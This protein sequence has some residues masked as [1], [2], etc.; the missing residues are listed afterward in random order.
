MPGKWHNK[1]ENLFPEE[2]REVKFF[3]SSMNNNT[4]RRA[5]IVLNNKRTFEIQHSYME[6][7]DFKNC[8]LPRY[9]S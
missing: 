7:W 8:N 2:M 4:C 9:Y 6:S 5:D 1:M 3:C